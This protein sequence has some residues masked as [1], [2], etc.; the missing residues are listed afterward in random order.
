MNPWTPTTDLHMLRRM[1]KLQEELG[2][3]QAVAARC[4]IQG[5][6]EIDPH[7]G[8]INR[9]RLLEEMADVS[10]QIGCCVRELSLDMH[11][12][13]I[14]IEEKTAQMAEWERLVNPIVVGHPFE[15]PLSK[16]DKAPIGWSC[17][18]I[19]GHEG[20]CAARRVGI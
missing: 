13:V 14:R 5:I 7:S 6:D 11:E 20:P 15:D 19:K 4:I 10:A 8:E 17:S 9:Q 2:E 18:R 12:Y 3:L 16:C 1:G